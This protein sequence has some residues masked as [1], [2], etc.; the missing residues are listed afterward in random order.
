M[1]VPF[2]FTLDEY[3]NQYPTY[4]WV[5]YKFMDFAKKYNFPVIAQEK[6]FKADENHGAREEYNRKKFDYELPLE[7]QIEENFKYCI[8]NIEE[9][10]ILSN[11]KSKDDNWVYLLKQEDKKFEDIIDKKLKLIIKEKGK[12]D[13]VI[14][15]IWLPSLEKVCKNNNI[16]LIQYELS[17]IRKDTFRTTLGY[18]QFHNKYESNFVKSDYD[19]FKNEEKLIFDREELLSLFLNTNLIDNIKYLYKIA[20]YKIGYALGMDKD[21]FEL[22]FT[23]LSNDEIFSKIKEKYSN[24]DVLIRQHPAS[25]LDVDKTGFVIDN[26]SS[27]AEWISNC[28]KI[29]CNI[30]NVAYEAMLYGRDVINVNDVLP[31][32]FDD[33]SNLNYFDEKKIGL[34][35]LNFLTFYCYCP[36]ELMFDKDY[37][38]YRLNNPS[39]IDIYNYHLKYILSNSNMDF[40]KIK[41]IKQIK[42]LDYILKNVHGFNKNEI[43]KI[44]KYST[45]YL[46]DKMETTIKNQKREIS[47]LNSQIEMMNIELNASNETINSILNSV[48]WKLTAPL[49]QTMNT[50]RNIKNKLIKKNKNHERE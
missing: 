6:F 45:S 29:I 1:I 33:Y 42:R 41:Q 19:I 47:K 30:S 8:T 4:L 14:T 23:K 16:R 10:K 36:Y 3:S 12:I 2:L 50:I 15:W 49:R 48:S 5:F 27:T 7:K 37:I 40:D 31:T 32:A 38:Y 13:A 9:Q 25:K 21:K 26:S 46:Y 35:K 28:N 34:Q 24:E 20:N 44:K 11:I 18:F 43:Q 39:I 22:A 17:T